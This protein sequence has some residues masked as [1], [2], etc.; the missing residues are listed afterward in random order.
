[1]TVTEDESVG[2]VLSEESLEVTEGDA[3]GATYTVK[4]ASEPAASVTVTLS[5]HA[6]SDLSLSGVTNDAL[7]FTT[8]NWNT[9]QT[10]TVTAAEDDDMIDDI[11]L[12]SHFASGGDYLLRETLPLTI[13]ENDT[14]TAVTVETAAGDLVELEVPRLTLT[15]P[16][17]GRIVLEWTAP[18]S[19]GS[20]IKDYVIHM[21]QG[22]FRISPQ[23]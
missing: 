5:G 18:T 22:R 6:D 3:N 16:K 8:S 17:A 19:V 4:L 1:M 14:P 21:G 20:G 23:R 9:A 15:S 11:G 13:V 10:I 12:L 7:T 2:L